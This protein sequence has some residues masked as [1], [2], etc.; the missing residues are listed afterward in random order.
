LLEFSVQLLT[1]PSLALPMVTSHGALLAVLRSARATFL[2]VAIPVPPLYENAV[3]HV[4]AEIT[5]AM[6]ALSLPGVVVDSASEQL[7]GGMFG[8]ELYDAKYLLTHLPV[9][10]VRQ[11]GIW[12]RVL[13]GWC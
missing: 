12:F 6:E 4:P 11:S 10:Q 8:R 3:A 5:A 2:R 13:V 9:A 7:A 1:V